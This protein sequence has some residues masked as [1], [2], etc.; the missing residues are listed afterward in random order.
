MRADQLR[1][2][3]GARLLV[4]TIDP[5]LGPLLG[6]LLRE[7]GHEVL[8]QGDADLHILQEGC[9]PSQGAAIV[10]LTSASYQAPN[11]VALPF[12]PE[13]LWG[14]LEAHLHAKQRR[15]IRLETSLPAQFQGDKWRVAAQISSLSDYGARLVAQREL[16]LAEEIS[17]YFKIADQEMAVRG[18]II[19]CMSRGDLDGGAG[20]EIGISFIAPERSQRQIL[21]DF[22][23]GG[24]LQ[25][26]RARGPA[27]FAAAAGFLHLSPEVRAHLQ[28]HQGSVPA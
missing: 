11:R 4:R 16:A 9:N 10:W 26:V 5:V 27:E 25:R 19:Y 8:E 21:R 12:L 2:R 23:V 20:Y 3:R 28:I 24:Y 22:I 13:E 1:C 6:L 7:W 18:R 17:L 14:V 15:H